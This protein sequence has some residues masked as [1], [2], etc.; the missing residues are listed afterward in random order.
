[1]KKLG[2]ILLTAT[3]AFAS[4]AAK[5]RDIYGDAAHYAYMAEAAEMNKRFNGGKHAPDSRSAAELHDR[6]CGYAAS[7]GIPLAPHFVRDIDP[8][9]SMVTIED[10]SIWTVSYEDQ[11]IVRSWYGRTE[12]SIQPNTL[13]FWNKLSG[14]RPAYK[15]NL[16]NIYTG[17]AVAANLSIGPLAYDPN[18]R[19]IA[20]IDY[21]RGEIYLNNGQIWK[22]DMSG[23]CFDVL[24]HWYP[25]NAVIAGTN[26]T[27]FSLGN[28]HI[29]ICV[30]DDNWLPA[31]RIY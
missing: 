24:N 10:G 20:S 29:L 14:T 1:M 26:D 6:G 18:T 16:V 9:G 28:P 17:E 13:S 19:S 2:F 30:E 3:L 25:G 15:Y 22:V 5:P 31:V 12:L 4:L 7:Y 27:W 11:W 8:Y 21:Y 23:T